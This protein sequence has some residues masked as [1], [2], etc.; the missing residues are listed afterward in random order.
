MITVKKLAEEEGVRTADVIRVV[1]A[2]GYPIE[3]LEETITVRAQALVNVD[4]EKVRVL[5]RG[6]KG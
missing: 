1:Q 4:A 5:L 6:E 2:H 3:K